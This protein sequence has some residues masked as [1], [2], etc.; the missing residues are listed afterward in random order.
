MIVL[1]VLGRIAA[2]IAV[3][4]IVLFWAVFFG[5]RSSEPYQHAMLV[6]GSDPRAVAVLGS[7]VTRGWFMSGHVS[8]SSSRGDAELELAVTGSRNNGTLHVVGE[9]R[10]GRWTYE[11]LELTVDGQQERINLLQPSNPA[12]YERGEL[13]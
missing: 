5:L 11:T 6:A 2:V 10:A 8:N 9:K 13:D 7:P 1:T 4:F 12:P 3:L